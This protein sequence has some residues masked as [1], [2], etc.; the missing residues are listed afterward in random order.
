MFLLKISIH[1]NMIIH[2]TW[3]KTF[4]SLLFA[5]FKHRKKILEFH[6]TDYFKIN[7][8]QIIKMSRK[9]IVLNSITMKE[10]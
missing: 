3:T 4:L 8:K 7:G 10:K 2:Y 1:L 6:V 5:S 9:V